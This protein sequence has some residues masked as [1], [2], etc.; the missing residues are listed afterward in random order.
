MELAELRHRL[1]AVL[2]CEG[3]KPV[4]WYDVAAHI[5]DLLAAEEQP[6]M[7]PSPVSAY[8]AGADLRAKNEWIGR[9][10]RWRVRR[11]L[12]RSRTGRLNR[13]IPA[14]QSRTR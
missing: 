5:D 12:R 6:A 8:L 7:L 11:F 9:M 2:A 10:Q 3:R 4:D 1:E 14:A 13:S